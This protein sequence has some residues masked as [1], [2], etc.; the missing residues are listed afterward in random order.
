ML[1]GIVRRSVL[2]GRYGKLFVTSAWR[3]EIFALL[4]LG[5]VEESFS[6]KLRRA[7]KYYI[8]VCDS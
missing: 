6:F 4:M 5:G 8:P 3:C 1:G 7:V 2:E